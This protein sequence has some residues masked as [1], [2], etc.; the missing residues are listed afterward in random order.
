MSSN[1]D[2]KTKM[3]NDYLKWRKTEAI[4]SLPVDQVEKTMKEDK[5][6]KLKAYHDKKREDI[7]N[8]NPMYYEERKEQ[9]NERQRERNRAY[10]EAHRD[11]ILEKQKQ[12]RDSHKEENQG[13]RNDYHKAY[14]A[15][16][17]DYYAE[18][19]KI[20]RTIM[21]ECEVCGCT[22]VKADFTK[23]LKTKKHREAIK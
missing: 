7:L 3:M 13:K 15:E 18:K 22:V 14:Y 6:Q 1:S 20:N 4:P 19:Q 12:Y 11:E 21:K 17:K 16:N 10:R 8:E 5:S 9:Q 23:H 2:W